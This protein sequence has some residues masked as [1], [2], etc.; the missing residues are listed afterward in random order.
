MVDEQR[1]CIAR[2]VLGIT[3]GL[4]HGRSVVPTLEQL[5]TWLAARENEHLEFKEAKSGFHFEKLAKYCAA[6][7]NEGGGSIVLGVT[8]RRPRRVV[9]SAAFENLERTK[10]GLVERLRLRIEATEIFHPDGRVVVF[11][12]PARPV[13]IPISVD[14]A[15]W[16]RA[17]ED[18]V[19][20][21]SD[22]LH[23]I[24]DERRPDFTAQVCEGAGLADLDPLAIQEFRRRWH[25]SAGLPAILAGSD[26]QLL[27]DAE[28]LL[29][30]GV[31]YAGLVLLGSRA[32][33]SKYLA[34]AEI[35]FE[36]RSNEAPGPAN[37]RVELRSAFV[38]A[39]DR[40]WD[41]IDLRNDKQ[42]YQYRFVMFEVPT[43][44]E[45]SA[46]E[47]LLN[48][49]AHRDYRHPGSIFVR[50]Y[51]R[52]LEVV[53]PGG[54][55]SGITTENMLYRQNPRNRRLADSFA[56][57]GFVE[58]AG[59]GANL[60]YEECMRQ[61]KPLPDFTHTDAYQVALTLHGDVADDGFLQ[62]L[63]RVSD[64][65]VVATT[66][67]D[68]LVFDHVRRGRRIPKDLRPWLRKLLDAGV[69]R[70]TG[71]GRG[72]VYSFSRQFMTGDSSGVE[73][74]DITR[75]RTMQKA[76]LLKHVQ[77]KAALGAKFEELQQVL[78]DVGRIQIQRLMRE[79]RRE[80]WVEQRGETKAA[81][82]FVVGNVAIPD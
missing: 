71:R 79:L 1:K 12:A 7:A 34:A 81:R 21:T 11:T 16:M 9:G 73:R 13:G 30:G 58:R 56:R 40:V 8:D 60:I 51:P 4:F 61:G 19:P 5:R 49:V 41:L 25:G 75:D 55:P 78:P 80:G 54:F 72:T 48:A 27:R 68:L 39:Y 57:C 32:A 76:L 43:F 29:D 66:T 69:L 35:V 62:F 59:Q 70:S 10:A 74:F 77:S 53:S 20:M 33:L 2:A 42:H 3:P 65:G 47:A 14:G 26:E 17:G 18:L 63:R 28:L 24:F 64:E 23:R 37:Q 31:T 38:L 67:Q 46:R 45:R 6:L 15:Y 36:Y 50:Q 52:R 22:M 44:S 82:W